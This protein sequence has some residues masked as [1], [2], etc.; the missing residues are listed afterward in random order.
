MTYFYGVNI[1]ERYWTF[2]YAISYLIAPFL[3]G[4][5]GGNIFNQI[6]RAIHGMEEF[7]RP[8]SRTGKSGEELEM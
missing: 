2:E 6:K 3:G 4:F 7:D 8:G 1:E 5:M